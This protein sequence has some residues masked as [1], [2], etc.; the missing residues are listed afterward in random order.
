MRTWC[1]AELI[2]IEHRAERLIPTAEA[3]RAAEA[4]R[5]RQVAEELC[6]HRERCGQDLLTCVSK[7]RELRGRVADL[8][9]MLGIEKEVSRG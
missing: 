6:E 4:S 8:E 3:W 1:E 9:A 7:I 2:E 5:N